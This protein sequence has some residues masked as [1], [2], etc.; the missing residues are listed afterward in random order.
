MDDDLRQISLLLER[1]ES[2][3]YGYENV[4]IWVFKDEFEAL[5]RLYIAMKILKEI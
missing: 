1:I 3:I 4:K 5:K 2:G